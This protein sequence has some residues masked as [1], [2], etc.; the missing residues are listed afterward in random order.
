MQV[1]LVSPEQVLYEG[2]AKMVVVRTLSGGDIAFEDN[3]APFL[4]ALTAWPARVKFEDG[5]QR[6]FAVHG[7]FVEV[8]KNH[9]IILSD[10]AELADQIDVERAA[11]AQ[12]RAE[13]ALRIDPDDADALAALQR[14]TTR[15]EVAQSG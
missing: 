9:V 11:A 5:T 2:E 15:L 1:Q 6:W 10:V 8:S 3:H 4:G 7:G 12:A 14:A 13:E